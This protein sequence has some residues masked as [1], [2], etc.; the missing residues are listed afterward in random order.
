MSEG[1]VGITTA[2]RETNVAEYVK[3]FA[4]TA[5]AARKAGSA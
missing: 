1:D 4:M 3:M 2:R 5:Y